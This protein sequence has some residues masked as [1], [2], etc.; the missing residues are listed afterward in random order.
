MKSRLKEMEEEAAKLRAMQARA[1]LSA[2][3]A[4]LKVAAS[5]RQR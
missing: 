2:G 1:C 3:R 4:F 5:H